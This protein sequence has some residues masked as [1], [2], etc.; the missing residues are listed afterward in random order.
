[1][2]VTTRKVKSVW[3]S[4]RMFLNLLRRIRWLLLGGA[5]L[6]TIKLVSGGRSFT[7]RVVNIRGVFKPWTDSIFLA[8]SLSAENLKPDAAVLDMCAGSGVLSIVAARLGARTVTAVDVSRSALACTR[9]NALLHR[10]H[11]RTR[12]GDLF[13]ALGGDGE[14]ALFDV[15]VSNPPWIPCATDDLPARGISRA[16]VAGRDG[17]ALIDRVCAEAPAYLRPGGVLLIVQ[18]SFCD[19]TATM[20]LLSAQG[21]K[22]NVAAHL[23]APMLTSFGERAWE[24]QQS[25]PWAR[26]D[27][28]YEIVVIRASRPPH[29][30]PTTGVSPLPAVHELDRS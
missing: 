14:G 26:D 1:M 3:K 21:L 29:H 7:V 20:E 28:T 8:E 9:L 24:V 16:W 12:R 22:V 11:V 6:T 4:W 10:V 17:R 25:G 30:E 13:A 15:V 23:V 18:A 5:G 2:A 27:S 19:A